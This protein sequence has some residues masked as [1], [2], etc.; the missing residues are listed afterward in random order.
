MDST[1]NLVFNVFNSSEGDWILAEAI[2]AIYTTVE[3]T[4]P[5]YHL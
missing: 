3:G 5:A 4:E 2:T 1:F